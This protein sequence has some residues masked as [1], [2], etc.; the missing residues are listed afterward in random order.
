M[1]A[2]KQSLSD[3]DLRAARVQV[4]LLRNAPVAKRIHL[5]LSLTRTAILL[6]RRA[7]RRANP[8]L[9][10]RDISLLFVELHYGKHLAQ[11]MRDYLKRRMDGP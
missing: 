3:T 9:G 7:I 11:E 10:E 5:A 8:G 1:K 6:S 4:N 2:A